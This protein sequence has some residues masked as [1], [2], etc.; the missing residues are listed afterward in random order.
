MRSFSV[1]AF[2]PEVK[3]AHAAFQSCV[4]K[5]AEMDTAAARGLGELRARPALKGK[6]I[7]EVRLTIKELDGGTEEEEKS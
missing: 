1:S 3:P 2:F 4:A 7:R 6:R 5:A